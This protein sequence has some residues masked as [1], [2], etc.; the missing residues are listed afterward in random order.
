MA[1]AISIAEVA[2]AANVSPT[3]V[4]HVLSL[5]R[6]VSAA[7][8]ARVRAAMESLGFVPNHA[9]Q[10]LA[11]GSTHTLGLLVPD[12][13][14]SFFA[15][16]TRGVEDAAERAG[17]SVLMGNTNFDVHRE[18]R[19]LQMMRGRHLDGLVYA[20]GAPPRLAELQRLAAQTPLALVDE[21]VPDLGVYAVVADNREGG[22]AVAMLLRD[23]GHRDVLL[24]TGPADLRSS[25]D[26]VEAFRDVF[27]GAGAR[28]VVREGDFR[29]ESG[30]V[31][32]R[33]LFGDGPGP[34]AVFALNDMMAIG[35]YQALA[36]LGLRIPQDVS[37]VGYDAIGVGSVLSPPLTSVRQPLQAMGETVVAGLVAR[38]EHTSG[39]VAERVVLP[40]ELVLRG[41][42]G[43]ATSALSTA[44]TS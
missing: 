11:T 32:V 30:Y 22:A 40:V 8:A 36:E 14:N 34:T 23:M 27:D 20:A 39:S 38:I 13:S 28:T 31:H 29:K 17:Y 3:T 2:Q 16:L 5:R 42:V 7:T 33:A 21:E 26:R 1:K 18:M 25:E 35:A 6:P 24:I 43:V 15:E 10:S 19:Y 37:V 41:S 9:A 44:S 4:S 12:I